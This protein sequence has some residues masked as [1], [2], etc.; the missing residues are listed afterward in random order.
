MLLSL[1]IGL[2]LPTKAIVP[3]QVNSSTPGNGSAGN[4]LPSDGPPGNGSPGNGLPSDGPP[5]NNA[6]VSTTSGNSKLVNSAS[7]NTASVPFEV[8]G[9]MGLVALGA[10]LFYR[11]HKKRNQ[12]LS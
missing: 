3:A 8:E 2:T 5:G 1:I 6:S 12:A 7:G 11:R 4:G 9:T 10:Y